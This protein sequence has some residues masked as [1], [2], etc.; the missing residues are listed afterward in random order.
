MIVSF[1]LVLVVID[2]KSMFKDYAKTLRRLK[3]S[4]S[5]KLCEKTDD[6]FVHSG[7]PW[8]YAEIVGEKTDESVCGHLAVP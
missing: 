1:R 8:Y 5:F 4:R 6:Q 7:E 2:C 3:P